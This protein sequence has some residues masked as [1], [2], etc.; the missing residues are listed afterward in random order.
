MLQ[1]GAAVFG[2]AGAFATGYWIYALQTRGVAFWSPVGYCTLAGLGLGVLLML[3]GFLLPGS[4]NDGHVQTQRGGRGST[5]VQA[6][7][8]VTIPGRDGRE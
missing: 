7:R 5:N 4:G 6:G 1:V 8:D 2:V 3:V